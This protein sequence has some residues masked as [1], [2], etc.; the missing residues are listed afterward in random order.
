M[1]RLGFSSLPP[2]SSSG[3][4]A[5][6]GPYSNPHTHVITRAEFLAACEA[7]KADPSYSSFDRKI[8]RALAP[9]VRALLSEVTE[10]TAEQL[11]DLIDRDGDGLLDVHDLERLV[12]MEYQN[13]SS[14]FIFDTVC[15]YFILSHTHTLTHTH[16]HTHTHYRYIIDT[17]ALGASSVNGPA[18]AISRGLHPVVCAVSGVTICFGGIL[19]DLVCGRDVALGGQVFLFLFLFSIFT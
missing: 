11:F 1:D 3:P 5:L 14:R 19:R 18:M 10:P 4:P 12:V 9:K 16:S 2:V 7:S 17:I 13:S 15:R 6:R 8:R